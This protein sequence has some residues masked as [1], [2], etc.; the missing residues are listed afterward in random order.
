MSFGEI[1]IDDNM[2][3]DVN[4]DKESTSSSNESVHSLP[5]PELLSSSL[6]SSLSSSGAGI[7][8]SPLFAQ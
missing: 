5:L 8:T 6:L 4:A 2:L 3:V 7:P 1:G